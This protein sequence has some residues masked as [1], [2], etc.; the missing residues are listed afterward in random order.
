[1]RWGLLMLVAALH[2]PGVRAQEVVRV[3][4][5]SFTATAGVLFG[6][7][8]SGVT[9]QLDGLGLGYRDPGGCTTF[10]Y[11]TS[12]SDP[13]EYPQFD[14][15]GG[16]TLTVRYDLSR[17]WAVSVGVATGDMGMAVGNSFADDK[18]HVSWRAGS[19]WI[20][21]HAKLGEWLSLGAGPAWHRFTGGGS[22]PATSYSRLG[23]LTEI[24]LRLPARSRFFVETTARA[25]LVPGSRVVDHSP[26]G[27]LL[28]GVGPAVPLRLTWGYSTLQ[29]GVGF[30]L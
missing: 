9:G 28:G 8:V 25:H 6:G 1:M 21:G 4:K 5:L 7:P 27:G 14:R 2:A 15:G 17:R 10:I 26:F 3:R 20:V 19:R 29:V 22:G 13:A 12:C 23:L 11:W 30:R 18:Y 16:G 24:A